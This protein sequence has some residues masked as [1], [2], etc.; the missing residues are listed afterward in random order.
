MKRKMLAI[1]AATA[2]AT[3]SLAAP[4]TAATEA[5]IQACVDEATTILLNNPRYRAFRWVIKLG[6]W[7]ATLR[8]SCVRTLG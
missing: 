3:A 7:D 2:F 8:A 6:I 4:T 1:V 5:E